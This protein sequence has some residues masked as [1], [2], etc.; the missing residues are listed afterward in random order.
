MLVDQPRHKRRR[1]PSSPANYGQND[2]GFTSPLDVLMKRRRKHQPSESYAT[3]SSGKH[4]DPGSNNHSHG[5]H[6][7]E[8]QQ[9]VIGDDTSAPY[10]ERR[11]TKHWDRLNAPRPSLPNQAQSQPHLEYTPPHPTTFTRSTSYPA[12]QLNDSSPL[13]AATAYS[14]PLPDHHPMSSSP[15]RHQPVGSSPFKSQ[16]SHML[17]TPMDLGSSTA[18][19]VEND[20]VYEIDDDMDPE[21]M[22]RGWGDQYA[23]QNELL[24]SVVSYF[25]TPHL[26]FGRI[27]HSFVPA[28]S[29]SNAE[30]AESKSR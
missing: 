1:S 22:R 13:H 21:E 11:R 16:S 25:Q 19:R 23:Q 24:Y 4:V 30:S 20:P 6:Q 9:Q 28:S 12:N 17:V 7:Q 2:S 26:I 15:V 14:Q 5:R 8:Y 27:A 18:T 29:T 10:I 3:G